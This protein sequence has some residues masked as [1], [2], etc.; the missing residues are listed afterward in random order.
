[1]LQGVGEITR[2]NGKTDFVCTT[3]ELTV[4]FGGMLF[5]NDLTDGSVYDLAAS[6][7]TGFL[8]IYFDNTANFDLGGFASQVDSDAAADGSLFLSLG[9][10]TLQQGPGYTAQV[11]HLDS[12]WSVSGGA[13]AEY[14][15]TDSQLFGSD[16]GF[17]ATVDFQNN[18]YGIGGGVASGNS[19]P[20]PTSLAIFGLGLLGLAGAAHRKA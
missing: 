10:D 14:F 17:A 16:L 2:F 11:G 3:C 6:A 13:A 5:D 7:S 4:T 20:E 19:I 1:M 15:D 9:F 18:L 8:N 12:F